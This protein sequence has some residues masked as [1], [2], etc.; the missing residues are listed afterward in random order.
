MFT[1]H[2]TYCQGRGCEHDVQTSEASTTVF[3]NY[4]AYYSTSFLR[5]NCW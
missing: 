3:S 2:P 4:F 5:G 1:K